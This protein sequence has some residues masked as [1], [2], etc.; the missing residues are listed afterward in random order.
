MKT[1]IMHNARRILRSSLVLLG[2]LNASFSANAATVFLDD[3][4]EGDHLGWLVTHEPSSN[5]GATGVKTNND[6][7]M[8]YAA[9]LR[10]TSTS[11]SQDFTYVPTNELAFTMQATANS[12]LMTDRATAA[13]IV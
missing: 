12:R 10:V 11:L 8:A 7:L 9:R 3:F 4:E 6:S 2:V 13:S 5:G 1:V